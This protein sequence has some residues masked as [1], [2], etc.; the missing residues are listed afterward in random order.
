VDIAPTL[1]ALAG[2]P[3]PEGLP[4]RDLGPALRGERLGAQPLYAES[5]FGRLNCRWASLRVL[6]DGNW[7]LIEGREPELYDLARDPGETS[8][9]AREE[10]RRLGQMRAALRAAVARMA[11]AGD[12]ARIVAISPEQVEKLR[13]LGY[14]GGGSAGAGELDDRTLPDPRTHV[15]LYERLQKAMLVRGPAVEAALRDIEEVARQDAGNPY[16]H[17]ALGGVAYREGRLGLAAA[18]YARG[19]ELDPDRPGMRLP[20]GNLLRD[21]RRL[22]DSERQ[23]RIAL[24]Q[25]TADDHR[26]R[27][28]LAETLLARGQSGEAEKLLAGV[29]ARA[30]E[31]VEALAAQAQL[32][33]AQGRP[34]EAVPLFE[35]AAAAGVDPEPWVELA[36]LHITQGDGA[37]AER[38]AG[39]ALALSPRHPWALAITGHA[40]LLGG[41]R[42]EGLAMLQRALAEHPRRPE[43][44]LSL[45]VAFEAAGDR[46]RADSCR[47]EASAIGRS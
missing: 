39:R 25:T 13:S 23:L 4:G 28:G 33:V 12:S 18:A 7:K 8:D 24:E 19:L 47:R 46:A 43:A 21:M 1:L 36:R 30:P 38:A 42:A 20:Y 41:R 3:V 40:L 2:A 16:A 11:P 9:R 6:F 32:R 17:F 45:A 34:A 31:H 26:T 44:W 27:I 37:A 10:P 22:E 15:Q 35:R 29:L 14:T 5:L